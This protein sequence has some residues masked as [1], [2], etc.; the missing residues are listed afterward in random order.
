MLTNAD[1]VRWAQYCAD[2]NLA[3]E[4]A[5]R[6]YG[7]TKM[8]AMSKAFR[9]GL[10]GHEYVE[11]AIRSHDM[12]MKDLSEMPEHDRADWRHEQRMAE[13]AVQAQ[14]GFTND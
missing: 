7:V 14:L 12:A 9:D 10:S 1:A 5:G 2:I 4:L 11:Q 3:L 13:L 6:S 8:S